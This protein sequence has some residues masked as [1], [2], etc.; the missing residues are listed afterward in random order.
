MNRQNI[1]APHRTLLAI[2]TRLGTLRTMLV[3]TALALLFIAPA[4]GTRPDYH[5]WGIIPTLIVP[6]LTPIV[7]MVL[8][9]DAMMNAVFM[10]DKRGAERARHKSIVFL[11]LL[12][13][14]TLMAVWYPYFRAII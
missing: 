7:F 3:L 10:V 11:Q 4:P 2:L 8:L 9:L 14:A 5:G 1:T 6:T 13:T 12:L